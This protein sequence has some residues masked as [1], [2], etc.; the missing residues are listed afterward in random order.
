MDHIVDAVYRL[1]VVRPKH[2]I[3]THEDAKK[4]FYQL[5]KDMSE[6][7]QFVCNIFSLQLSAYSRG[8]TK[9]TKD[10]ENYQLLRMIQMYAAELQQSIGLVTSKFEEGLKEKLFYSP[11]VRPEPDNAN[12]AD[13][14][15][16]VKEPPAPVPVS[17]AEF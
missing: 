15:A 12:M 10:S 6:L 14:N 2:L 4:T 7:C 16:E 3:A 1:F 17:E 9:G 11:F 8:Q 13:D 5:V